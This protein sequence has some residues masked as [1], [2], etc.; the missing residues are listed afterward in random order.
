MNFQPFCSFLVENCRKG[1]FFVPE[2]GLILS[3]SRHT[4]YNKK[5]MYTAKQE[6]S[7]TGGQAGR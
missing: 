6:Y 3:F 2:W 7:R 4:C 1:A 5:W